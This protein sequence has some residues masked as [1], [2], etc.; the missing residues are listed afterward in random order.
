MAK[1]YA[2][3]DG[4]KST[5]AGY[6]E[7]TLSV[8]H[9]LLRRT[10][11]L[12]SMLCDSENSE[13]VKT[14]VSG[15]D[16]IAKT[17]TGTNFD[18]IGFVSD[19]GGA[20]QKGLVDFY[21][22]DVKAR[23]K[24]C[25]FHFYQDRNRYARYCTSSAAKERFKKLT[26]I[27]KSAVT[28]AHY[29]KGLEELHKFIQE[30]P[31]KRGP[32]KGFVKFWDNKKVRFA[33]CYKPLFNAPGASKGETVNAVAVNAG[34]KSLA[35]VDAVLQDVANS[36]LLKKEYERQQQE[37]PTVGR[38]PTAAELT[39]REEQCQAARAELGASSLIELENMTD[40]NL[41]GAE[42][43]DEA[44]QRYA[45]DPRSSH[46]SDKRT[47]TSSRTAVDSGTS[48]DDES[49][50]KRSKKQR[51]SRPAPLRRTRSI[52]FNESLEKALSD[53]MQVKN[54]EKGPLH[55]SM[56]VIT[57]SRSSYGLKICKSP[58]C[59]CPYKINKPREV[60]KHIIW[61]L[62]NVLGVHQDDILLH[63]IALTEGE[64]SSL[65]TKAPDSLP[66]KFKELPGTTKSA[67]WRL[68][69]KPVGKDA[70]CPTCYK[71]I[72]ERELHIEATGLWK[73]RDKQTSINRNFRFC[74]NKDCVKKKPQRSQLTPWN[75][76]ELTL[77]W[78]LKL[79]DNDVKK[80]EDAGFKMKLKIK[81]V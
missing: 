55:V 18:P 63:Q 81:N 17:V 4:T 7:L 45:V 1:E 22:H 74:I 54:Y 24:A 67:T 64:L 5:C 8:Y 34:C 49:V 37:L 71:T 25:D 62:L 69:H 75:G 30:K 77:P 28:P 61:V 21:G 12:C 51:N 52:P 59:S 42:T 32:I 47:K 6:T 19:E 35:L 39:A 36:I 66:D 72:T 58:S 80:V 27:W 41:D 65:I 33:S 44:I 40:A 57:N 20:I 48:S 60:C 50:A 23:L 3:I 10:I 43:R 11:K 14:L 73:P 78:T 56:E 70:H 31:E 38:G 26:E 16:E 29:K 2:F 9:P 46:R 13:N 76:E 53:S 79:S 15:M 68:Q